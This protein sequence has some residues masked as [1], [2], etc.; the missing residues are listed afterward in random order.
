MPTIEVPRF[1]VFRTPCGCVYGSLVADQRFPGIPGGIVVATAD[2]AWSD[3][4]EGR[5]RSGNTAWKEG[6]YVTAENELPPLEEWAAKTFVDGACTV[7]PK[8]S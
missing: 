5:K 1:W 4:Y 2:H 3:F 7:H 6:R 8:E